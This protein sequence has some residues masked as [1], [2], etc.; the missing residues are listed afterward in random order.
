MM[1]LWHLV[2]QEELFLLL[3]LHNFLCMLLR[4]LLGHTLRNRISSNDGLI[5][6]SSIHVCWLFSTFDSFKATL[7][8]WVCWELGMLS[9][10]H[11][12]AHD[13]INSWLSMIFVFVQYYNSVCAWLLKSCIEPGCKCESASWIPWA[14][15]GTAACGS[16]TGALELAESKSREW[17]EVSIIFLLL[18]RFRLILES[19]LAFCSSTYSCSSASKLT[20]AQLCWIVM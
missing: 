15:C 7:A 9:T 4:L 14:C 1:H 17:L 6:W 16:E 5:G 19:S 3:S 8:H 11:A 18:L 20:P 2:T 13:R 12:L 10:L